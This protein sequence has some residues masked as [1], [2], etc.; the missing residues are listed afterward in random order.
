VSRFC[1][2]GS[3]SNKKSRT[4]IANTPNAKAADDFRNFLILLAF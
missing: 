1:T 2:I 3:W 4:G